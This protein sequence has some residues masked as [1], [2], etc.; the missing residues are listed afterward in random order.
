MGIDICGGK[1][2]IFLGQRMR[3]MNKS[4]NRGGK[5]GSFLFPI[6]CQFLVIGFL[7]NDIGM[8]S[9]WYRNDIGMSNPKKMGV[10][11][12]RKFRHGEVGSKIWI[13]KNDIFDERSLFGKW[14]VTQKMTFFDCVRHWEWGRLYVFG[15][16][17]TRSFGHFWKKRWVRVKGMIAQVVYF[18]AQVF[19]RK[20]RLASQVKCASHRASPFLKKG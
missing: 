10:F 8:I 11:L 1:F 2:T 18:M 5:R 9:E 3:G 7:R 4:K 17:V 6:C 19:L 13:C 20:S 15:V 12:Y 16:K 14:K